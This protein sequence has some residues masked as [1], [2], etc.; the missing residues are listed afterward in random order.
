MSVKVWRCS[1]HF[2]RPEDITTVEIKGVD[3]P[4]MDVGFS[5]HEF[6]GFRVSEIRRGFWRPVRKVETHAWFFYFTIANNC[7]E[8]DVITPND[9]GRP[10]QSFDRCFPNNVF[11]GT[12]GCWQAWIV[13]GR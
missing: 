1:I 13:F 8:K 11:S 6:A 10:A 12:P 9:R 2:R 7:C 3:Q 4:T 5:F